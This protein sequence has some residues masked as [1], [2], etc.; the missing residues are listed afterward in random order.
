MSMQA[1]RQSRVSVQ[2]GQ[3]SLQL[4]LD[5]WLL[6]PA[7]TLLMLGLVMVGSASISIAEQKTGQ[8]FYYLIRQS[9]YVGLGLALAWPVWRLP[10]RLW[11]PAG[12][13][14][15]MGSVL[16]LLLLF[17]PGLGREV[18]GS[19][20]W[21]ALGP[22]N[23]QV[24]ELVK[25]FVVIYLAGY[26]V[27]HNDAVRSQASGFLR[28]LALMVLLSMLLLLEPDFGAVAVMMATAMGMM[29]LGGA[30]LLQFLLLGLGMLGMLAL[31]A[32]AAPYRMA[33]LT[34]FLNPWADPFD[35][36]FQLTQALIAFGRGEWLGVGLGSSVQKLF[37]LPEAHTDFLFA[38]MAEEL[39]LL[40]VVLVIVLFLII[41]LRALLIGQRAEKQGRLFMAYVAYGLGIWIGLQAFINIGV[42]MGVLPTKGLTLPLM[43]YGG[44]SMMVMCIAMALLLRIESETRSGLNRSNS[45]PGTTDR[46]RVAHG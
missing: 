32:V 29:W 7:L 24:S 39:G 26:L 22:V 42:N 15:I 38:V 18:N 2:A 13:Y 36:G 10:M 44:S 31:L 30:R 11:Q 17:V 12:P 37:Y 4:S 8:P 3:G 34:T 27:R 46:R 40:V 21:L 45:A 16:L 1:I 43:S 41:V 14:L 23:L 5:P 25:L 9:A 28:P 19:L 33:R 20:R 35:S 6:L